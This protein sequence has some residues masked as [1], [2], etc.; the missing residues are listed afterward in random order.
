L[1][2]TFIFDTDTIPSYFPLC[3]PSGNDS[4]YF[5]P[6]N[7]PIFKEPNSNFGYFYIDFSC[8]NFR[9]YNEVRLCNTLIGLQEH[10]DNSARQLDHQFGE[11]AKFAGDDEVIIDSVW[12]SL[13]NFVS[14]EFLDW[15]LGN[16]LELQGTIGSFVPDINITY[17]V[18]RGENEKCIVLL[19]AGRKPG[20]I[21]EFINKFNLRSPK[22][23]ADVMKTIA[24]PGPTSF[25]ARL[26]TLGERKELSGKEFTESLF[27]REK[28]WIGGKVGHYDFN[29]QLYLDREAFLVY[30]M[31][32]KNLTADQFLVAKPVLVKIFTNY[33]MFLVEKKVG[34][35]LRPKLLRKDLENGK[36]YDGSQKEIIGSVD[37]LLKIL[38]GL[39]PS[40]LVSKW[41]L[42]AGKF[43]KPVILSQEELLMEFL[44]AI[45]Y[46]KNVK[47]ESDF[48]AF[49]LQFANWSA[50]HKRVIARFISNS[51]EEKLVLK[52]SPP[53]VNTA[54]KTKSI[55]SA[56]FNSNVSSV[57][58]IDFQKASRSVEEIRDFPRSR[59]R[60]SPVSRAAAGHTY[61]LACADSNLLMMEFKDL[62]YVF[63]DAAIP[64]CE[65]IY[66]LLAAAKF[67][68]NWSIYVSYIHC[69]A[70]FIFVQLLD[71]SFR[72]CFE[73]FSTSS[74][75]LAHSQLA[76][77]N[78]VLFAGELILNRVDGR[79]KW[80]VF[81]VNNGSGHY[82][83]TIDG[84]KRCERALKKLLEDEAPDII[85]PK[86]VRIRDT[87][88]FNA[89]VYSGLIRR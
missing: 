58:A 42:R 79:K 33:N 3:I 65:V 75:R 4:E 43:E 64:A 32:A 26:R 22:L 34:Y 47:N 84:L 54:L 88:Q 52:L 81:E 10:I 17:L 66:G 1:S 38:D 85:W 13:A 70:K 73:K 77:G 28:P 86:D 7:F 45:L 51:V 31:S 89:N 20:P 29:M 6:D 48:H 56:L 76:C 36:S 15:L 57:G 16:T 35:L 83:P 74:D 46:H 60:V 61:R 71:K 67:P 44:G 80:E 5:S 55:S 68:V 9:R 21:I 8:P 50:D 40:F 25:L 30:M 62:L 27:S 82:G 69:Q 53:F 78:P 24:I 39:S 23:V 37:S 12:L 87:L 14:V 41:E 59:P 2:P 63:T 19:Q 72:F 18:E 49:A 11:E